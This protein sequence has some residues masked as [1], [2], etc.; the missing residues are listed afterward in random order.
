MQPCCESVDQVI[1][2]PTQL[3]TACRCIAACATLCVDSLTDNTCD[4]LRTTDV[5]ATAG[6]GGPIG[7]PAGVIVRRQAASRYDAAPAGPRARWMGRL[8]GP[9]HVDK[10][11]E[12]DREP[13][14]AAR[15]E[16]R[17]MP[18]AS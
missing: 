6:S 7:G 17:P 2:R 4:C 10:M 15:G 13:P 18:E 16:S 3:L 1:V 11:P 9:E 14:S 12:P 8:V 5:I